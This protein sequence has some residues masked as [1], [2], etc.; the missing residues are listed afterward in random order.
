MKCSIEKVHSL[1]DEAYMGRKDATVQLWE[2]FEDEITHVS[3]M[4]P[5]NSREDGQQRARMQLMVEW[6]KKMKAD[7]FQKCKFKRCKE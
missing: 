1:L 3:K 6:T 2:C 5:E 4:L 7:G